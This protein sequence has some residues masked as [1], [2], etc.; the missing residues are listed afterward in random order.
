PCGI[1]HVRGPLPPNRV[2]HGEVLEWQRGFEARLAPLLAGPGAVPDEEAQRLG[3][4]DPEQELEKFVSANTQEL[5]KDKWLCPLSGKKF[6][7]PEFVRKH[8]FNK[9]SDKMSA[10]RKEVLFF[11]NFLMDPKRPALPEG[12][13]GP[14][15]GPNAGSHPYPRALRGSRQ[16]RNLP[17]Q[18]GQGVP[19]QT[20]LQDGCGDPRAIVEYRDLDALRDVDFF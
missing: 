12:K 2:S 5:G 1:I 15:P 6:K 13:G 10:V 11:N 19:E 7:G 9:H 16:L 20:P 14:P 3:R 4:K 8:I 18:G 17:G